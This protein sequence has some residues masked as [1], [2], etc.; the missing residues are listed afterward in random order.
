[1]KLV[2]RLAVVCILLAAT[3]SAAL[4]NGVFESDARWITGS[5]MISTENRRVPG[6]S[7]IVVE[8]SGDVV[9]SQG[10]VQSVSVEADDNVLPAVK[11]EVIG[12]VLHLGFKDGTHVRGMRRL[13]F[14]ITAVRI[15]GIAISGSGSVHGATPLRSSSMSLDI[16]GSGSI[17]A[18]LETGG[19]DIGIHGSG[20]I[21]V[22]GRAD[23]L[24]VTIS[25]SGGYSGRE[26]SSADAEVRISGSG[27]AT[28][29]AT[30]TVTA[31]LSGSGSVA[32][33]G[34][35]KATVQVSGSGSVR[36]Y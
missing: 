26:L 3:A 31:N 24:S 34:G 7:R 32:Y 27:N 8:G 21:A 1:V 30:D 5:G 9:I 33:G 11:T 22:S 25:G 6:F 23:H 29:T 12:G 28:V 19:L 20:S 35:A 17:T 13:E 10:L 2:R 36:Q 4:A 18:E 15:E 16:G 14:R